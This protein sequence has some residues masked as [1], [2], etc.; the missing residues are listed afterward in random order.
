MWMICWIVLWKKQIA[1]VGH[2]FSYMVVLIRI[3]FSRKE[4]KSFNVSKSFQRLQEKMDSNDVHQI[5]SSVLLKLA[6]PVSF[7]SFYTVIF[8]KNEIIWT[9]K[10]RTTI[11]VRSN[12]K[13]KARK[14]A[15]RQGV[16]LLTNSVLKRGFTL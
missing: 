6:Y 12:Y 14:S 11:S 3:L 1:F 2:V 9:E 5:I 10:I 15:K 7:E 8:Y 13:Q 4:N 16:Y